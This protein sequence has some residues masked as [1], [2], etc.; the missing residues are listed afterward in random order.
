MSDPKL[1]RGKKMSE[2]YTGVGK[3]IR[4]ATVLSTQLWDGKS[5]SWFYFLF[6]VP[7]KGN[8]SKFCNAELP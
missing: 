8:F 5:M 3:K 4:T 7:R 2:A 6:T 1:M